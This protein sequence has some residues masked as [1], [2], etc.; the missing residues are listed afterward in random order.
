[1]NRENPKKKS[2]KQDHI[3]RCEFWRGTKEGVC[4]KYPQPKQKDAISEEN[5]G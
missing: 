3:E 1:M 2:E 5:D 4:P